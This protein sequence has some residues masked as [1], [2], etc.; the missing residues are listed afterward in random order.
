MLHKEIFIYGSLLLFFGF[1][2]FSCSVQ[3]RK[4]QSGYFVEW[5]SQHLRKE[6]KETSADNA[7]RIE[8]P[9]QYSYTAISPSANTGLSVS[10]GNELSF[11]NKPDFIKSSIKTPTDSCDLIIFK[12]GSEV[13]VKLIEIS[14]RQIKYKKCSLPDGPL[15]VTNKAD[16]FMI[17]Y[18][19]G[20]RELIKT[21]PASATQQDNKVSEDNSTHR[22]PT[23][24]ATNAFVFSLIGLY[25]FFFPASIAALIMASI[26]IHR[27][28]TEPNRYSGLRKARA[29]RIIAMIGLFL[30]FCLF[31]LILY[32]SF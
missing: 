14:S 23:F 8:N 11:F 15:Y 26:Q 24:L 1:T 17:K 5:K 18:V 2:L 29:A 13:P 28:E 9:S 4:Y 16:L 27:I 7:I 25:P 32:S 10:S 31:T 21:E 20:T 6:K 3:K 19:N 22:S 30:S 12:D